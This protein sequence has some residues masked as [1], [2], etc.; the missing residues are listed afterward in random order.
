MDKTTKIVLAVIVAGA[1]IGI[2]W[3]LSS[4]VSEKED[5]IVVPTTTDTAMDNYKD[6]YIEG[7]VGTDISTYA[8]C[9]CTY[10]KALST[11]GKDKLIE[12]SYNYLKTNTLSS[13]FLN[14]AGSCMYLYE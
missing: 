10:N 1:L 6:G 8:Y 4:K 12:E 7:C 9:E 11:M 2:G 5:R 13:E 3:G 14:V